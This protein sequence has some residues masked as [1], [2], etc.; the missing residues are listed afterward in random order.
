MREIDLG[1]LFGER[2]GEGGG[3]GN[4]FADLLGGF[5]RGGQGGAKG[6]KGKAAERGADRNER[7]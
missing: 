7:D 6:R 2:F 3:G 5:R 4:P 1:Q